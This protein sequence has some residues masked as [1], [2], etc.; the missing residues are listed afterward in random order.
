MILISIR[1]DPPTLPTFPPYVSPVHCDKREQSSIW[2]SFHTLPYQSDTPKYPQ[3]TLRCA[4]GYHSQKI[5][6]LHP[7]PVTYTD[8]SLSLSLSLT[9]SLSISVSSTLSRYYLPTYNL[10]GLYPH[11]LSYPV[12]TYIHSL[13]NLLPSSQSHL[14]LQSSYFCPNRYSPF[15]HLSI[16]LPSKHF[17]T[18]LLSYLLK[19]IIL[20]YPTLFLALPNLLFFQSHS[21]PFLILSIH[22]PS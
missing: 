16:H 2:Q 20:S 11:S 8:L 21:S 10:C 17:V 6:F 5:D 12:Y 19:F 9:L 4:D 14:Q 3:T 18:F 22:L 7:R 13:C 15:L 1:L